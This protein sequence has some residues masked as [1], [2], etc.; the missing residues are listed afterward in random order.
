[1][2]RWRIQLEFGERRS[3]AHFVAPNSSFVVKSIKGTY[4]PITAGE[5]IASE[6]HAYGSNFNDPEWQRI[7]YSTEG[8]TAAAATRGPARHAL[9]QNPSLGPEDLFP[10][11]AQRIAVA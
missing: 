11:E 5:L 6:G 9:S 10:E 4:P 1:M 7:A 2:L 3:L 8:F